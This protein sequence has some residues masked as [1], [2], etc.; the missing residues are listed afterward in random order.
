[1]VFCIFMPVLL[2]SNIYGTEISGIVPMK[3]IIFTLS[4][5]LLVYL[6]A[7]IFSVLIEKNNKSRGS[8]IQAIYRSNLVLMGMPLAASIYGADNVGVTAVLVA[9][10][11]PIYNVLAVITL[12][13][14]RG[15]EMQVSRVV[16]GILKNPLI[17]GGAAGILAAL[18][19]IRLPV[20]IEGIISDTAGAATPM[21]LIVLGASIHFT[22]IDRCRRNLIISVVVRLL[23][24]PAICLSL[25]AL[26][27]FRGIEFV[28]LIAV[29][30]SPVAVSSFTMAKQMNSDSDL[31][32]NNVAFTSAFACLTMFFWIFLFKYLGMF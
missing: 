9:I 22:S 4:A 26:F 31:A 17:I 2:F 32:A 30:A 18:L 24:V 13:I 8:I 16:G 14:F 28:T 5:V 3:L 23:V 1:M 20:V 15:T 6:G 19:N 7:V 12:E 27:G 25:G 21:A 11:V 10:I 29:F